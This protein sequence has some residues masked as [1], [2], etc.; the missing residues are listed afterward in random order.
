MMHMKWIVQYIK[1]II[2]VSGALTC[3]MIYGAIAPQ[4]AL[5][6][7][8]GETLDGPLASL[9]VRNWAVLITL[10]GVLLIYGAYRPESRVIALLIAGGSKLVFILLV[11]AHGSKYL[12]I[13]VAIDAVWVVVFACYL[14]AVRSESVAARA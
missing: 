13:A 11:L 5:G 12:N 6:A 4:A 10:M 2:L 14:M 3:T 7:T 9:L 8:F 1:P